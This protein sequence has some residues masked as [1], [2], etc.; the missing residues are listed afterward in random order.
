MCA[1]V[2]SKKK[3]RS[4][5]FLQR[6]EQ[7]RRKIQILTICAFMYKLLYSLV[8]PPY[9]EKESIPLFEVLSYAFAFHLV[10]NI[11]EK[12][13]LATRPPFCY[14]SKR[15]T[16]SELS[17]SGS[18][19]ERSSAYI[20]TSI[21]YWVIHSITIPSKTKSWV[22]E[23]AVIDKGDDDDFHLSMDFLSL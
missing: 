22:E 8:F 19:G 6:K 5:I 14:Q 10:L 2:E 7:S 23:E 20:I 16:K 1:F 3:K 17:M 11:Q 9:L 12:W 13:R 18:T 4:V 21:R 15:G